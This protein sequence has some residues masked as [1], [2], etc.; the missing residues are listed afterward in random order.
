MLFGQEEETGNGFFRP[1]IRGFLA[2]VS[3]LPKRL[4]PIIHL[5]QSCNEHIEVRLLPV[6]L[7]EHP[8]FR[9]FFAPITERSIF[10]DTT[11]AQNTHNTF[12]RVCLAT[13]QVVGCGPYHLLSTLGHLPSMSSLTSMLT[14]SVLACIVGFLLY[15][16]A[17]FA[18]RW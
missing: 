18:Y 16:F 7:R 8:L 12:L 9:I 11:R 5:H 3:E 14:N 10:D 17:V 15:A 6:G 4:W 2:R 13:L 1:G